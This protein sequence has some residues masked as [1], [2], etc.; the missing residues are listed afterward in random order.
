MSEEEIIHV[1]F[2]T[3]DAGFGQVVG[4]ALGPGFE[5][6]VHDGAA[7]ENLR[8]RP[9]PCDGV[10]LDLRAASN[11]SDAES[12]LT[13]FF[14]QLRQTSLHP[15]VIVVLGDDDPM[16]VCTLI[17]KGAYDAV[18]N[19]PNILELRLLLRRAHRLHRVEAQLRQLRSE[20]PPAGRLDELIGVTENMQ[21]TF[22]LARKV[23]P[24]DVT[25][26]LTGETGTGKS[27]LARAIHRLS[28]RSAAQFVPFSCANLPENLAEDELF[29][30]ERG[31]FTGAVALRRGRFEVA[32]EGTLFL[33][34]VGDLPLGLQAKLLR[35][36]QERT[37]ERLGSNSSLTV[38]IR[39]ICATHRSL[40][41]MVK[42][43]EFREDLYYR[44]NV[45][46]LHLP[47][48]RE[49]RA[50]IAVLAQHFVERFSRE[51]GSKAK[52]LS[53]VAI[54][55]LEDYSWPG[56]V[57][58]LENVVQ[59]AVVLADGPAIEIWDLPPN[60]QTG[61]EPPAEMHSYEDE[62]REFKRRLIV[63]TLRECG[64]NK[65]ETARVLSVARGY[66]HRL[67]NDLKIQS[68]EIAPSDSETDEKLSPA[69]M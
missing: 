6:D 38:D 47:P 21:R 64:G 50:E 1:W 9:K 11:G 30:H 34:E 37:F 46:Q 7:V 2:D 22:A 25:V 66:L 27:L 67:I 58:E 59:R 31:A 13:H 69:V 17:E 65:A 39:L 24:C 26:L 53:P 52:S 56:N 63:R 45:I 29:G 62:I 60:M 55:A 61:M 51:F 18:S 68:E 4:R 15:P 33:D 41:E 3:P 54:R 12:A 23:A 43:G 5:V 40:D 57:R 14:D 36:L 28:A 42:R 48:L 8:G 20:L 10:L 16:L 35:V 32:D 44:L 19:P 49:R